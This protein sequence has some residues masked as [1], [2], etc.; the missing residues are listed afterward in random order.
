VHALNHGYR[1]DEVIVDHFERKGGAS[2]H[3]PWRLPI[4]IAGAYKYLGAL[5]K[6][7]PAVD[8]TPAKPT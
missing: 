2:I 6:Q 5:K 4:T 1:V 8:A 3:V 7:L